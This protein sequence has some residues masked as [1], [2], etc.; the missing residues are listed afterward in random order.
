MNLQQT[1]DLANKISD[2]Q[3]VKWVHPYT[4]PAKTAF[5]KKMNVIV[6][7][8]IPFI[9]PV[10]CAKCLNMNGCC[11]TEDKCPE[12]PLHDNCHCKV[13]SIN[14]ITVTTECPIEKFTG[15]IFSDNHINNGKREMFERWGFTISD[16]AMLKAELEKQAYNAYLLGEYELKKLSKYGQTIN[17]TVK[18]TRKNGNIVT[19]T[20][21]WLVYPDGK[22]INATPYGDD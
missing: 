17:I 19:F 1:A 6:E 4:M 21:G 22:I 10:H 15:Y 20:T 8:I 7:N 9:K 3:W 2:V 12:A 5:Q 18:L 14:N 11:F 16:S 13:K